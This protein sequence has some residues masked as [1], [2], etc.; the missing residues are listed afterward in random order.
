[1]EIRTLTRPSRAEFRQAVAVLTDAFWQ[2]PLFSDFLFRGRMGPARTFLRLLL[3]FELRTGRVYAAVE[4]GAGVVA[5]ALWSHPDSPEFGLRSLL[6]LGLLPLALL[7]FVQSPAAVKRI[8]ELFRMLDRFAPET[9]CV[10]LEF[11]S[12]RQKGAGA[13]LM[14][15]GIADYRGQTL[16]VESIVSKDEHAYYRRF[17]FQPFARTVFHGTDYAFLLL[18]PEAQTRS[19]A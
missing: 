19:G 8:G 18:K 5:C 7:L 17:G 3:R 10:T 4:P 13:A 2:T 12:S 1:M 14:N 16:Y 11:L 15:R 9:P 6:R